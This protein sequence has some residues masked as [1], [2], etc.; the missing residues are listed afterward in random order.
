MPQLLGEKV[1]FLRSQHGTTQVELAGKLGLTANAHI[2]KIEGNQD[3]ASLVL[4]LGIA[5]VFQVAADYLLRDTVSVEQV[6]PAVV[7]VSGDE[8]ALPQLFGAKLRT[9]RLQRG[10]GQTVLAR[11]LG[12]ARRGYISNLEGARGGKMPSP[13]LVVKIADLF[14]VT[15]DE[16][17]CDEMPTTRPS[18]DHDQQKEDDLVRDGGISE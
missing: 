13:E 11:N 15:T 14:G 1:R 18:A 4:I 5:R 12:L 9:L 16:L 8:A 7:N 3:T 17:L 6:I 10:W 2:S